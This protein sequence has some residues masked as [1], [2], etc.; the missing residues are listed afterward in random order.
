MI[1]EKNKNSICLLLCGL[2]LLFGGQLKAQN[3]FTC[4]EVK[5]NIFSSTPIEDIKAQSVNAISVIIPNAKQIVFQIPIK[6][7]EFSRSL[8][9]E[10]FN[11]DYMES[12]KFPNATF[13]GNILDQVDFE[14]DGTYNVSVK[15]ILN[16]H[17]ISKERTIKGIMVIKNGKPFIHS[18]FNVACADHDIKIPSVVFK[19]I[20]EVITVTVS[21]NYK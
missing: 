17:G 19:K 12:N 14:K 7:F 15:G 18:S 16:I 1:L 20:A 2:G 8:M 3:S 11:D 21:G 5:V 10:H 4:K 9:K 13:K 6:S